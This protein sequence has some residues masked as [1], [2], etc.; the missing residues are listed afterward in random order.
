MTHACIDHVL[1]HSCIMCWIEPTLSCG[2]KHSW[3]VFESTHHWSDGSVAE[4]D[5]YLLGTQDAYVKLRIQDDPFTVER[6]GYSGGGWAGKKVTEQWTCGSRRL[7]T[8][9]FFSKTELCGDGQRNG[10]VLR[11]VLDCGGTVTLENDSGTLWIQSE[12][13]LVLRFCCC[14]RHCAPCQTGESQGAGGEKV[15]VARGC[16]RERAKDQIDCFER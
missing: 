12:H 9:V 2:S 7:P 13:E 11:D 3:I 5:S 14:A 16:S 8:D 10:R 15:V 1:V 6:V 4:S